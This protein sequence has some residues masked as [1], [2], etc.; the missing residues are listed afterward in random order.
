MFRTMPHTYP[1]GVG[2]IGPRKCSAYLVNLPKAA[3]RG[4]WLYLGVAWECVSEG[5]GDDVRRLDVGG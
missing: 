2:T 1:S 3:A 5:C 4:R